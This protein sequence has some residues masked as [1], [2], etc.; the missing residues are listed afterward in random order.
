MTKATSHP[1]TQP[2]VT[3]ATDNIA[4]PELFRRSLFGSTVVAAV[5]A[6]PHPDADL[7]TLC[8]EFHRRHAAA[9]AVSDDDDLAAALR[10]RWDVSDRIEDMRP[11]TAAGWS[12]KAAIAFVLLEE[13][14]GS[15]PVD[16]DA[17]FAAATLR[18]LAEGSVQFAEPHPDAELLSAC[19]EFLD[20]DQGLKDAEGRDGDFPAPVL[21][22]WYD[23]LERVTELRASTVE[24]L[25]AKVGV[26]HAAMMSVKG[27]LQSEESAGLAVLA[28]ILAG[29]GA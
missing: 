4:R 17:R 13:N 23:T 11:I 14:R 12:A 7:L 28:D 6:A 27:E 20:A 2:L 24:G 26:A 19:L 9:D 29:A 1:T 8:A 3:A 22:R 15:D 16:V 25:R 5:A 18:D 21:D 10:Q